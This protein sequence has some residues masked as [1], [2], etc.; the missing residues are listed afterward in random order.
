MCLPEDIALAAR[1]CWLRL[2]R[3][4][5]GGS[6]GPHGTHLRNAL[7][8]LI[9]CGNAALLRHFRMLT[10]TKYGPGADEG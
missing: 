5:T 9:E 8:A 1:D 2:K 6:G 4:G 7:F 3:Y 10:D